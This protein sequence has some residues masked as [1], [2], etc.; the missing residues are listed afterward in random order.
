VPSDGEWQILVD[1]LGGDAVAGGKMKS[2]GTIQGGD[3]LW[4]R[5]NAGATN[6]S[7]F[8]ALPGGYRDGL[9]TFY[10]IGGGA[11]FWSST[12]LTSYSAWH[13]Y[14]NYYNSV[15]YRLGYTYKRYG[16]SVRC[17]RD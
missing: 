1:Y 9:G 12:E 15:I 7:G 17:V 5:P 10:G 14:L 4:N 8:S 2:T 16:F 3:G 6:E 11:Y 13:R